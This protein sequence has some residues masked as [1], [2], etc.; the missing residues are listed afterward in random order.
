MHHLGEV[1]ALAADASNRF[2]GYGIVDIDAAVAAPAPAGGLAR[3]APLFGDER[4]LYFITADERDGG[5]MANRFASSPHGLTWDRTP[6]RHERELVTA[7]YP[8][9]PDAMVPHLSNL[10]FAYRA[11]DDKGWR[12]AWAAQP[13]APVL[14][15]IEITTKGGRVL[16]GVIRIG[17]E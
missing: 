4:R 10:R 2:A 15:R 16:S 13:A 9:A 3:I 8:N 12:S 1:D 6:V 7:N 11:Q 14:V 5:L 17:G